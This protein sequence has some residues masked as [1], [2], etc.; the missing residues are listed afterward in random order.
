MFNNMNVGTI[1]SE[2]FLLLPKYVVSKLA[3]LRYKGLWYY[4][5]GRLFSQHFRSYRLYLFCV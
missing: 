1:S 5:P 3:R 2:L 4:Y